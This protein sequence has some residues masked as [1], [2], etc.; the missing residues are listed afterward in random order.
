MSQWS[1]YTQLGNEV[2]KYPPSAVSWGLNRI[3]V[4]VVGTDNR[5]YTKSWNG[6][7]WS[8][9]TQLG[10]ELI[11]SREA[12]VSWVSA[13][14]WGPNR[15]DVFVIGTDSR[16]YTKSWDG[17]KWSGYTQLGNEAVIEVPSAVSWGPNRIDVFVIGTDSRLYTKSWDGTKWSGYTQ[18]SDEA[19]VVG[20]VSAVSWGPNRIDIFMIGETDRRLYTKS[21]DGTKW[22]SYT[23]L[24][25]ESVASTSAVSW[26]P[27]RIDVFVVGADGRL[28]T[29]SWDGTKWSG[30]AQLGSEVI[31]LPSAVSWGPNRIDVFVTGT[32]NKLYTKFWDGTKWSG[33][34]KLGDEPLGSALLSAVSWGPNRIDLFVQGSDG[35]LYTKSGEISVPQNYVAQIVIDEIRADWTTER[36]TLNNRDEAYFVLTGGT[37]SNTGYR[38][39]NGGKIAPPPPE[40]YFQFWNE[41]VINNIRLAELSLNAG[42]SAFVT[43]VLREQDNAQL[44]AIKE[45]AIA[46][47]AGI[48]AYFGAPT[49]GVAMEKAKSAAMQFY[50]SL[51]QD[52]HQN[53]GSF[54]VRVVYRDGQRK[55]EWVSGSAT[56]LVH[57]DGST[58]LFKATDSDAQYI[59]RVSVK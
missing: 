57:Q 9:Y 42:E 46:A 28:Y 5:L 10:N 20:S 8:S 31:G 36:G 6:T 15:I 1:G 50:E 21:W 24:G 13:V 22:S 35:K 11:S 59:M 58:A 37:G 33:Y 38:P 48:A 12:V 3:D 23:Q 18:L 39:V 51:K 53:I 41:T 27:N 52:G 44:P 55:V 54:S 47:A 4:F 25:N 32:D 34:I 30:Y 45:A 7:K 29:K 2:I 26:G 43:V 16:L 40:D 56:E 17:T 14:S 49:A 19:I